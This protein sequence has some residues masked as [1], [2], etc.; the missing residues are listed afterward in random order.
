MNEF[1][2]KALE[3]ADGM[4]MHHDTSDLDTYRSALLAHLEGG[5]QK[6][7]SKISHTETVSATGAA[8]KVDVIHLTEEGKRA[9]GYLP[10]TPTEEASNG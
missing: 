4:V 2:R 9:L 8:I 1:T 3:F 6:P 10:S 5:Q 7:S